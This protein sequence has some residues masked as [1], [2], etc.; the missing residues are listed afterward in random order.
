MSGN[1]A[2][3]KERLWIGEEVISEGE[4]GVCLVF[5]VEVSMINGSEAVILPELK[6]PP[7]NWEKWGETELEVGKSL[8]AEIK[9]SWRVKK[10]PPGNPTKDQR[11]RHLFSNERNLEMGSLLS[12]FNFNLW[13]SWVEISGDHGK[14]R[15]QRR[16]LAESGTQTRRQSGDS[17]RCHLSNSFHNLDFTWRAP[18][19]RGQFRKKRFSKHKSAVSGCAQLHKGLCR[20]PPRSVL[21]VPYLCLNSFSLFFGG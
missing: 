15:L 10:Q 21:S 4:S 5:S 9:A 19:Q 17:E 18:Q 14:F 16:E 20:E 13:A 6:V 8:Q 12:I 11:R 3:H 1:G 7:S 2:H